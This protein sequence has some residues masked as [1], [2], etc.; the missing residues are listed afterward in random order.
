[1]S[2]RLQTIF[3]AVALVVATASSC[4]G[5]KVP[6]T[7]YYVLDLPQAPQPAASATL[8]HTA[9]VTP[10]KASRMLTRDEIVYRPSREEVGYYQYHRWAEDPR[11]GIVASL[12][13]QLG[14]RGTFKT[15]GPFDGRTKADFILRGRL[16]RLEEVDFGGGVSV[17]VEISA[18]LVD[19]STSRVVWQGSGSGSGT[20]STADVRDVVAQMSEAAGRSI[21]QIVAGLDR[22][23]RGS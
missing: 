17:Q 21:E 14:A 10:F 16:Q 8:A 19:A 9:V 4:G 3:A 5:G 7:R 15:V 20:V 23:L 12:I 6:P 1:M 13:K 22:H 2:R 11:E 18:E